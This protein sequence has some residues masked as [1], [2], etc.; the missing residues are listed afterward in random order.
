MAQVVAC[1]QLQTRSPAAAH[2]GCRSRVVVVRLHAT[3]AGGGAGERHVGEVVATMV[4]SHSR[5]E[6]YNEQHDTGKY[7]FQAFHVANLR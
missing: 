2:I 4:E 6:C 5:M 3:G 7:G 1:R